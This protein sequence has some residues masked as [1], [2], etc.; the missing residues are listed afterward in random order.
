MLALSASGALKRLPSNFRTAPRRVPP[1]PLAWAES[2]RQR[3][4]HGRIYRVQRFQPFE[5]DG[6][7][8][9]VYVNQHPLVDLGHGSGSTGWKT[10]TTLG[11]DLAA[12]KGHP[13]LAAGR[14]PSPQI[15]FFAAFVGRSAAVL[16]R[17]A[18]SPGPPSSRPMHGVRSSCIVMSTTWDHCDRENH[19]RNG[20]DGHQAAMIDSPI[21]GF[22]C[23]SQQEPEIQ[24]DQNAVGSDQ[25][26]SDRTRSMG[27]RVHR[28]KKTVC[29]GPAMFAV[30]QYSSRDA[31]T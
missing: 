1:D 29:T 5:R 7:N 21:V 22:L 16:A 6:G 20:T 18:F 24:N 12:F 11:S 14:I 19:G 31:E 8:T 30:C 17:S 15:E 13:S 26:V 2:R 10:M 28:N 9:V 25:V 3:F 4:V 27:A 23:K